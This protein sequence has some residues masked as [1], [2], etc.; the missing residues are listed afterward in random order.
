MGV[1]DTPGDLGSTDDEVRAWMFLIEVERRLSEG[2]RV[3]RSAGCHKP[4]LNLILKDFG[5]P[6]WFICG[7]ALS[8]ELRSGS[9]AVELGAVM[10]V[11]GENSDL[12]VCA[13]A[14]AG[15]VP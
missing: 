8:T 3:K 1:E 2:K 4:L 9:N 12:R 15:F 5:A 7:S 6:C 13:Q 14:A 10:P 11:C